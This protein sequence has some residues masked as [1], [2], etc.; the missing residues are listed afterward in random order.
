MNNHNRYI[1]AIDVGER[2]IG[3]ALASEIA[4]LPAP[5]ATIDTSKTDN[6]MQTLAEIIR[7]ENIAVIV[8][9]LPRNL[10]GNETQQTKVARKFAK[11]LASITDAPIV[12]QDEAATSL[13][14]ERLLKNRGT[15]YQ[16][17]D[18]DSQAA[19]IIL[20]DYLNNTVRLTA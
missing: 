20:Q 12:M 18:I 19:A 14:A 6:I 10:N 8:V 17:E 3:L 4:R 2:R 9:G 1:L 7:V 11:Q 15:N 13:E 5:F 16:K